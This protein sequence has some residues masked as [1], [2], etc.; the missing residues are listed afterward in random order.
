[1]R[2]CGRKQL[3]ERKIVAALEDERRKT[4]EECAT[5]ID[6]DMETWAHLSKDGRYVAQTMAAVVRA[7]AE[8]KKT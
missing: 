4:I 2:R 6:K 1:M 5:V 7:L 3:N 8:R